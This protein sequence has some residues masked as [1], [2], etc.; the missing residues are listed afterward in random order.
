MGLVLGFVFIVALILAINWVAGWF[1][2]KTAG[3]IG[4]IIATAVT[5]Y[6]I[7]GANQAV[8]ESLKPPPAPVC[9][10]IRTC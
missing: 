5:G 3:I 4:A 7:A 9:K 6:L 2:N 8:R 10:Q 1:D